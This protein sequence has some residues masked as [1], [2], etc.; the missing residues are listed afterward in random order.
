MPIVSDGGPASPRGTTIS[1]EVPYDWQCPKKPIPFK[2]QDLG[3]VLSIGFRLTNGAPVEVW[4]DN[5]HLSKVFMT[6]GFESAD[7]SDWSDVVQ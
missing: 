4:I 7:F 6:S 5:V 1:L 3:N 2:P